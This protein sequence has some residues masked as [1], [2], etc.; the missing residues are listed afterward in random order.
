MPEGRRWSPGMMNSWQYALRAVNEGLTAAAGLRALQAADAGIRK[1]DWLQL[2]RW[3]NTAYD[4]RDAAEDFWRAIDLPEEVYAS[5]P[6]DLREAYKMTAEVRYWNTNTKKYERHWYSVA[7]NESKSRELWMS[8]L[9]I[10]MERYGEF[11]DLSTVTVTKT[12]FW[13][14]EA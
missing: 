8:A 3:A 1:T 12:L 13:H 4:K 11:M 6:F 7:D 5:T 2:M 14:R 10:A 9:N